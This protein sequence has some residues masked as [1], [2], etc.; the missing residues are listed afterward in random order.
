MSRRFSRIGIIILILVLSIGFASVATNMIISGTAIVATNTNDFDVYF[1]AATAEEGGTAT[2]SADGKSITYNTKQ[3]AN[4]KDEARLNFTVTN[5]SSNYDAKVKVETFI[6]D[7][8]NG[9]D[10]SDY[11]SLSTGGVASGINDRVEA[12]TSKDGYVSIYMLRSCL[13]DESVKITFRITLEVTA[14]E[15]VR[16]GT[17]ETTN[18]EGVAYDSNGE[19]LPNAALVAFSDPVYFMTDENGHFSVDLPFGEH[20]IYYIPGKTI[21]ELMNIENEWEHDTY[22]KTKIKFYENVKATTFDTS[23]TRDIRFPAYEVG[24]EISIGNEK[25]QFLEQ[26]AEGN[27]LF[28]S[29]YNLAIGNRCDSYRD[30][31]NIIQSPEGLLCQVSF[32]DTGLSYYYEESG[33]KPYVDNYVAYLKSLNSSYN[34][35]NGS[36]MTGSQVESFLLAGS[37]LTQCEPTDDAQEYGLGLGCFSEETLTARQ[38]T[39]KFNTYPMW[40]DYVTYRGNYGHHGVVYLNSGWGS[41]KKTVDYYDN[42]ASIR[43]IIEIKAQR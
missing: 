41:A 13:S 2:I 1:S 33:L 6:G 40:I 25:F 15:R 21:E 31:G 28:I 34:I 22:T 18:L 27:Y 5:N 37:P 30:N 4:Y 23:Y 20:H 38:D 26:N 39:L 14:A 43:P 35:L 12:K 11:F 24:D 29:K 36:I 42:L 10:Y 9:F 19:I 16:L 17:T 7:A 8:D 3:L 32:D